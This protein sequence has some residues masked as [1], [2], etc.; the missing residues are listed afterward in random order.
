MIFD[1]AACNTEQLVLLF[2][3]PSSNK[4][5]GTLGYTRNRAASYSYQAEILLTSGVPLTI[6]NI[7]NRLP[8]F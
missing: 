4:V 3:R 7:T 1:L 6:A 5:A 8:R 2:R